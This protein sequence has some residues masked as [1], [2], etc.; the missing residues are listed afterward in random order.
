MQVIVTNQF[1]IFLFYFFITDLN[2]LNNVLLENDEI[3]EEKNNSNL[4]ES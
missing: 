4:N 1:F 3:G 2:A